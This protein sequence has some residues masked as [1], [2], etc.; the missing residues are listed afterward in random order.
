MSSEERREHKKHCSKCEEAHLIKW[1]DSPRIYCN[2]GD[3]LTVVSSNPGAW[4][5][6]VVVANDAGDRT[7]FHWSDLDSNI[8]EYERKQREQAVPAANGPRVS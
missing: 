5:E 3:F 2:V 8:T 6:V 4:K 1:I 7:F